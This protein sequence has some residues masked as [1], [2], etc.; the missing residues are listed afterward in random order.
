MIGQIYREKKSRLFGLVIYIYTR[1]NECG[2]KTCGC[3]KGGLLTPVGVNIYIYT[4]CVNKA[5]CVFI[6]TKTRYIHSFYTSTLQ[7]GQ[8]VRVLLCFIRNRNNIFVRM[9]WIPRGL[10]SLHAP[11][12][13]CNGNKNLSKTSFKCFFDVFAP[14]TMN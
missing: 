14:F 4:I 2:N 12:P 1:N 13:V 10:P 5:K 3:N 8:P 9:E 11:I 6:V 7:I